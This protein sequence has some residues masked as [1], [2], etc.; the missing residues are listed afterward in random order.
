MND[1][2]DDKEYVEIKADSMDELISKVSRYAY[3]NSSRTV[4]TESEKQVGQR[5]DF[6]G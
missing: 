5:F 6:R 1:P 4:L 3:D 2:M